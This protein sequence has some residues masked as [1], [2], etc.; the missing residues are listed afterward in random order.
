MPG[1][2]VGTPAAAD[3]VAVVE[4]GVVEEGA[5]EGVT[6]GE[7]KTEGEGATIT[8]VEITTGGATT[9]NAKLSQR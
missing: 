8:G 7:T 9:E 3:D 2:R 6:T 1:R 4:E 5:V